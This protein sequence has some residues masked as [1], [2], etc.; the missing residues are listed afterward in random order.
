[1]VQE[2]I[3]RTA[4]K[5]VLRTTAR[6]AHKTVLRTTHKTAQRIILRTNH[7]IVL[8]AIIQEKNNLLRPQ[9]LRPF[10]YF[11][12]TLN[13]YKINGWCYESSNNFTSDT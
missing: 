1:M 8:T 13:I 12:N 3:T 4:Q 5:T 2:A 6:I 9:I 7:L 11:M 10:T